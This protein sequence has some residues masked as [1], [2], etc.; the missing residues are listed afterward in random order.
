LLRKRPDL[1]EGKVNVGTD[2]SS[3]VQIDTHS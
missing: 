1:R 2:L 3:K